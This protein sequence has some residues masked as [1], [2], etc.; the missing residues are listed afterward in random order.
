MGFLDTADHLGTVLSRDGDDVE[1]SCQQL[2]L[3][4]R[5]L[6][7]S[8]PTARRVDV[9]A[10]GYSAVPDVAVGDE[11][12]IDWGRRAGGW[13]PKIR[14]LA[15][16]TAA[17]AATNERLARVRPG[18]TGHNATGGDAEAAMPEYWP[19]ADTLDAYSALVTAGR[20]SGAAQCRQQ[21][22]RGRR[23]NGGASVSVVADGYLLTSADVVA[24]RIVPPRPHSPTAPVAAEV[25]GRDELFDLAVLKGA[26]PFPTPVTMGRA[27]DVQVGRTRRGDR[28]LLGSPQRHGWHRLRTRTLA[29]PPNRLRRR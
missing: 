23:G 12:A 29:D 9:W 7:L 1:V 26:V 16:A 27:E 2:V 6:A 11:V 25:A 20:A 5:G 17:P 3:D 22:V 24:G 21:L 10:D 19:N 13:S 14:A 8:E 18:R 28:K 15:D 4:D